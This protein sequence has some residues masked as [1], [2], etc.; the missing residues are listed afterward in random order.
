MRAVLPGILRDRPITA[1][2]CVLGSGMAVLVLPSSQLTVLAA[3]GA[4]GATGMLI[5]GLLV[6]VGIVLAVAPRQHTL[7]GMAAIV[8]A[9]ASFLT[10]SLGGL[11]LGM[12]LGLVGGALAL[13]WVPAGT[14][15][16]T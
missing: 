4:A 2:Y 5:G 13:A 9:L 15:S 10:P 16:R 12:L 3:P 8:L 11:L 14:D 7:C 1:V 6:A